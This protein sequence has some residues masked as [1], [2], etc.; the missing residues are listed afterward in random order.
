[1]YVV[2]FDKNNFAHCASIL[3][4]WPLRLSVSQLLQQKFIKKEKQK[5]YKILIVG[6]AGGACRI[7]A[8]CCQTARP[9]LMCPLCWLTKPICL[10][11]FLCCALGGLQLGSLQL[12]TSCQFPVP[13][14]TRGFVC[15]G[16]PRLFVCLFLHLSVVPSPRS[17]RS[18]WS[19]SPSTPL[20]LLD[21]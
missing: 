12:A 13:G 11:G 18:C 21:H 2:Y 6:L 1:M 17:C 5:K 20:P 7:S 10:S 3:V 9:M 15:C 19:S 8:P 16:F 14:A 4:K